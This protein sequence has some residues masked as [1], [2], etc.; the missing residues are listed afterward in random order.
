MFGCVELFPEQTDCCLL[1]ALAR[2]CLL[3][4]PIETAENISESTAG[5]AETLSFYL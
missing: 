4:R 1:A 5:E 3:N 2:H